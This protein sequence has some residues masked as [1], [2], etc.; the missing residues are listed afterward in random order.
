MIKL[1]II[2]AESSHAWQFA[3]V[4]N[5]K[6]KEKLFS[7][8][9]LLGVYA[10]ASSEEGKIGI[11][12]IEEC[13]KC[14]PYANPNLCADFVGVRASHTK[15]HFT[16]AVLEGVA[17]SIYMDYFETG[18]DTFSLDASLKGKEFVLVEKTDNV[19]YSVGADAI[20]INV[21]QREAGNGYLVLKAQKPTLSLSSTDVTLENIDKTLCLLV[22]AVNE[23]GKLLDIVVKNITENGTLSFSE[24]GIS[25]DGAEYVRAYL[26]DLLD[27][28]TPVTT[29]KS[30]ELN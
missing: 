29:V 21:T 5:G 12:K 19:T 17:M 15:A 30:V 3:S 10:D 2:G 7:D 23:N 27:G 24:L 8:V 18:A 6:N 14:T 1:A 16:R 4:L 25:T 13:S 28:M 22:T 20:S 9:E 26:W 11:K